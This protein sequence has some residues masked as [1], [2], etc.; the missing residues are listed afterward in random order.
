QHRGCD[1]GFSRTR[2][3]D[4]ATE[5]GC[6]DAEKNKEQC[7]HPAEAGDFPVARRSDE[8]S[9]NRHVRAA[10]RSGQA[11]RSRQRQPEHAEAVGHADAQMDAERCWW[12]EPAIEA[13]F[14]Y[15]VLAIKNAR[16]VVAP[17]QRSCCGHLVSPPYLFLSVNA[18]LRP[19]FLARL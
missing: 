12:H 15:D 16:P 10:L 3:F 7:V 8:L 17:S 14:G 11:D 13:G 1:A 18:F 6:R 4:P 19:K 9:E 2:T 5:H